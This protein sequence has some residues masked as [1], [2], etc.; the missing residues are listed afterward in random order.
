MQRRQGLCPVVLLPGVQATTGTFTTEFSSTYGHLFVASD[1][2]LWK[3]TLPPQPLQ[4]KP[5]GNGE[6]KKWMGHLMTGLN[7]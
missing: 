1:E 4:K 2:H 6:A 3:S 5:P 7:V